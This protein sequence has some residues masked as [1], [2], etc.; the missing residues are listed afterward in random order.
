MMGGMGEGREALGGGGEGVM[1]FLG[2]WGDWE[3]T[4]FDA[5]RGE[6]ACPAIC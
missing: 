2:D 6:D 4:F 5:G 1:E 3:K